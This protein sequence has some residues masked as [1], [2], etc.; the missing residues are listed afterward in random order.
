MTHLPKRPCIRG[1]KV[2]QIHSPPRLVTRWRCRISSMFFDQL[3]LYYAY[4]I[5]DVS[6][7]VCS[8]FIMHGHSFERICTKLGMWYLY[9]LQM[10]MGVPLEPA[11]SR[12]AHP[13]NLGLAASNHNGLSARCEDGV[14]VLYKICTKFTRLQTVLLS[15]FFRTMLMVM[16]SLVTD[17]C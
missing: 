9:T 1:V 6:V 2:R 12:S 13:G 17:C 10:V 5:E 15:V 11:G 7:S 16:I 3:F 4:K 8:L 14:L